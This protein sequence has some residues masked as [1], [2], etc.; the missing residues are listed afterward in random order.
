MKNT[1]VTIFLTLLLTLTLYLPNTIAQDYTKW[2]LPEGANVRLGKGWIND[3]AYSQDSNRLAVASSIGIWI[4][5]AN[6]FTEIALL[7]GHTERVNAVAFSPDSKMLISGSHDK[8]V[9]L[10]NVET[11]ELLHTLE[12]HT[13]YVLAVAFSPDGNKFASSDGDFTIRLWD[14]H[15]KQMLHA[16]IPFDGFV[17]RSN[18]A[19]WVYDIAFSIDGKTL[20]SADRNNRVR[21]WDVD[22]GKHL[23]NI[24]VGGQGWG[25]KAV[26][27]SS[28]SVT[29]ASGDG[30]GYVKLWGARTGEFWQTVGYH[31]YGVNS[32]A[33]SP[34][35]NILASGGNDNRLILWDAFTGEQ[36]RTLEGHKNGILGITFSPD[37]RTIV[38]VSWTQIKFWD[39]NT[40]VNLHTIQGHTRSVFSANFS[41]DGTLL[42]SGDSGDRIML[43]DPH[44]GKL[45]H[46]FMGNM[47]TV[48]EVA[49]SPDG[50]ILASG[51]KAQDREDQHV[52]LWDVLTS[53]ELYAFDEHS[54]PSTGSSEDRGV[55]SVAFSPD[56]NTLASGG[57]E[58]IYLWDVKT[59][60]RIQR[61]SPDGSG[62]IYSI[63][64]SPDGQTLV[65]A[66]ASDRWDRG[67]I[68]LWL[69][70]TG[71]RL[72]NIY[73]GHSYAVTFS[74]DGSII[75]GSVGDTVQFWDFRSGE[76]VRTLRGHTAHITEIS[77]SPDGQTIASGS[78]DNTIRLYDVNTGDNKHTFLGHTSD[79]TD[80]S[81]SPD[82]TV[83]ASG[84]HDGTV[85]LW[86][87]TSFGTTNITPNTSSKTTVTLSPATVTS[88]AF[89]EQITFLL[90]VTAGKNVAGYQATVTFDTTALRYVES[91]NSN[92]LPAGA[93]AIPATVKG[94][95]VTLAA[96]SLAGQ[97][98][99]DG[100]LA[101]IT[102]EVVDAKAS[103]L[104]LSNVL[105]TDSTGG[106]FAPQIVA[107]EITE[108]QQLLEDVDV[109]K[110]DVNDDGIV[111]I[112]DL[113]LVA[114]NFGKQGEN[115]A[116]VNDDGI[117]NIVDLTL[118]AAAFGNTAAAPFALVPDSEL[119]TTRQQV[120]QWLSEA[121]QLNLTDPAFQRGIAVLEQLL[122]AV[123][124]KETLLLPNYPNPFNPETWIPYQLASPADVSIA[125]YAANGKLVRKLEL[126]HQAVGIYESRS[127]AA[128][129]N[130]KNV[131]GEPVASG[132]YFY[133]LT[134][135]DFT[136]TRKMLIRK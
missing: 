19:F 30:S 121:R 9:R 112:I 83:L 102:F 81:F 76:S 79:V 23:L 74:P 132:V 40:G 117:V 8:T 110:I 28:D 5:D 133:T 47:K 34:D 14:T 48:R 36:L 96:S 54:Y 26:A 128:Y 97:S 27:Y 130:G 18:E 49:F 2:N 45:T 25:A 111:N 37:G 22:T 99:G 93:F 21:L 127:R 7:T 38:S 46:T 105:L 88:P 84:S 60:E 29:L 136:A 1:L 95:T 101:T 20:A 31:R 66:F 10:W 90:K 53:S 72:R 24:G 120:Q 33:F 59:G 82:G 86:D 131:L 71:R 17:H 100:T 119:A 4:Y 91:D 15:R 129:W 63:A 35:G 103:T 57:A 106:S 61:L 16:M 114:S 70:Q 73:E 134:A 94:N 75:A 68:D 44:S 116:D 55:F 42:A 52:R 92:Y 3:I 89:G 51:H 50:N 135:G 98:N 13:D 41:P 108:P 43:W 69:P 109:E 12:D 80:L 67:S 124:P 126:G 115:D 118:V 107:A 65:S 62:I 77:F 87:I 125:I 39:P 78:L 123:T 64:F 56:G 113:T 6:T 58:Y 11:G 122:A 85:L 32:V 104:N